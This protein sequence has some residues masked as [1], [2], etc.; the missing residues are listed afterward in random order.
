MR[1]THDGFEM[2]FG[3]N[4]FCAHSWFNAFS[5]EAALSFEKRSAFYRYLSS[6]T[7]AYVDVDDSNFE[8]IREASLLKLDISTFYTTLLI[9]FV[10]ASL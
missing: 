3:T 4:Q 8:K 9:I 2:Q 5:R 10:K 7:H 1:L 6:R